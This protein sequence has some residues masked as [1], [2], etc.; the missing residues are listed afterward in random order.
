MGMGTGSIKRLVIHPVWASLLVLAIYFPI[1]FYMQ[2]TYVPRPHPRFPRFAG[3]GFGFVMKAEEFDSLA[4]SGE[5]P[6]QSPVI[7]LEDGKSLGPAHSRHDT[8]TDIGQGR[9]S[10]WK[11]VGLIFSTS[12]NSNPNYNGRTYTIERQDKP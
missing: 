9:F 10:H 2:S 4:D 12:D 3:G 5:A 11:G 7:V 6:N 1:A 8:I